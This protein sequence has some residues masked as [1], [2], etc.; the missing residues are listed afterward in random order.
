VDQGSESG[1][2]APTPTPAQQ[3][4][5]EIAPVAVGTAVWALLLVIGLVIRDDLDSG[6]REWWISSAGAG[7]VLGVVGYLY[8][9]RRWS[10]RTGR[11]EN[12]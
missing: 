10:R 8:L 11:S 5:A 9:R 3:R 2:A 12:T 1:S 4:A 7:V 6:G